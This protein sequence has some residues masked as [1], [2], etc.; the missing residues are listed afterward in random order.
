MKRLLTFFLLLLCLPALADMPG[1]KPRPSGSFMVVNAS[2]FPA[3]R[4]SLSPNYGDTIYWL[5]DST[6]IHMPG[7]RG[8]PISFSFQVSRADSGKT[9][10][11]GYFTGVN[12][13]VILRI[14]SVVN[15]SVVK[16]TRLDSPSTRNEG[17]GVTATQEPLSPGMQL[18]PVL[19]ASALVAL[20]VWWVRRRYLRSGEVVM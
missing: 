12:G 17:F 9:Y 6:L 13:H 20:L 1:S 16:F 8:A 14:D 10:N 3:F 2:A 18:L 11:L 7:G 19:G 5:H 15:D 4:F